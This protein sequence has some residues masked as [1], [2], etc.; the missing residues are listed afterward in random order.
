VASGA[1]S[2]S[3]RQSGLAIDIGRR[4]S[5]QR[6]RSCSPPP[7]QPT[8]TIYIPESGPVAACNG[9]EPERPSLLSRRSRHLLE[10]SAVM[11]SHDRT[12]FSS[13]AQKTLSN[14]SRT[15]ARARC[16][17]AR[18]AEENRARARS[19]R[20]RWRAYTLA[21]RNRSRGTLARPCARQGRLSQR[22]RLGLCGSSVQ[23][24]SA[25]IRIARIAGSA[26]SGNLLA[27]ISR[28]LGHAENGRP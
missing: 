18:P 24:D 2:R 10:H 28:F 3:V 4:G 20:P 21:R 13:R 23:S 9:S 15:V 16:W 19:P 11:G 12:A 22:A 26:R 8:F 25:N 5:R 1:P 17:S 6:A 14:E 27:A 7:A